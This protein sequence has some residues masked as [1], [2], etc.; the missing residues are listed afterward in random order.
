MIIVLGLSLVSNALLFTV[1]N[2]G[3]DAGHA[4]GGADDITSQ[5]SKYP[6]VTVQKADTGTGSQFADTIEASGEV[7]PEKETEIFAFRDGVVEVTKANLGDTV[8]KGQVLASLY[9]D[10]EDK[11]LDSETAVLQAELRSLQGKQELI[12]KSTIPVI[13]KANLT[14]SFLTQS[15]TALEAIQSSQISQIE[16]NQKTGKE[17]L[18]SKVSV[19]Q[20]AVELIQKRQES[21]LLSIETRRESIRK[22]QKQSKSAAING[23]SNL[24][25]ASVKLMFTE[26]DA[27]TNSYANDQYRR[28]ELYSYN[29]NEYRRLETKLRSFY[30]RFLEQTSASA[31]Q[32]AVSDSLDSMLTEAAELGSEIKVF[33]LNFSTQPTNAAPQAELTR[34]D[35][36]T[37]QDNLDLALDHLIELKNEGVKM[38]NEAKEL[39]TDTTSLMV[40]A[41]KERKEIQGEISTLT[42]EQSGD[43]KRLDAEKASTATQGNTTLQEKEN[44]IKEKD[45]DLDAINQEIETKK[46][47]IELERSVKQAEVQSRTKQIY[48]SRDVIAPFDGIITKRHILPGA[49][50]D[51]DKPLFS[52]VS[53]K[54][55]FI[56]FF[57]SESDLPFIIKQKTIQ[58]SPTYA[59][60]ERYHATILRISPT[61]DEETR[62]ILVEADIRDSDSVNVLSHMTVRVQVPFAGNEAMQIIPK[63]ALKLSNDQAFVWVVGNDL[64][65]HKQEIKVKL[66][67]K[68][69]VILVEPLPA[70]TWIIIKSPMELT[71]GLEI[72]TKLPQ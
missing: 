8:K 41:E 6:V 72:D 63:A 47:E 34:D 16:T 59:D 69:L 37:L 67:Y 18:E 17:V 3:A 22:L 49:S 70:K 50:V 56:R 64:R 45:I 65:A 52:L 68:E 39:D 42:S 20:N 7:F 43:A 28:M 15:L 30:S 1:S 13:N 24:I 38:E 54:K 44:Q 4:H 55:K 11:K 12:E 10:R 61:V 46:Q 71:E 60:L 14:K 51:S 29:G 23:V 21:D 31:T 2:A 35:V 27:L 53:D 36:Y 5:N 19:R 26:V 48:Y 57:V 62:T 9:P 66:V 33:S 40:Q 25:S 58:F 32:S